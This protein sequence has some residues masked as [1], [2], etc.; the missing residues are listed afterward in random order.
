VVYQATVGA[1]VL[2]AKFAQTLTD[3]NVPDIMNDTDGDDY[4]VYETFA[5]VDAS[6]NALNARIL[7]SKAK[8]RFEHG[9]AIAWFVTY[10]RIAGFTQSKLTVGVNVRHLFKFN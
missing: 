5:C 7:D 1:I 3:A 4:F 8:R 2:D 6:A 10:R 9:K